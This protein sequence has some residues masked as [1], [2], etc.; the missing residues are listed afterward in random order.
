MTPEEFQYIKRAVEALEAPM[1]LPARVKVE[2]TMAQI[3]TRSA[4]N[5]EQVLVDKTEEVLYN[6]NTKQRSEH[7]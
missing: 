4:D 5:L 6:S 3:L 7:A 2:R 1:S